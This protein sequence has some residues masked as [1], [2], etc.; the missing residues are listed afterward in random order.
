[1]KLFNI[2]LG[3]TLVFLTV[4]FL[5]CEKVTEVTELVKNTAHLQVTF[6]NDSVPAT[7]VDITDKNEIKK[8]SRFISSET[9]PVRKCKFDGEL[10]FFMEDGIA[11]G[12]GNSVSM[13]FSLQP[14]CAH[15]EYMYA[16]QLETKQLSE[17]GIEFLT[18]MKNK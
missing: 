2:I 16:D 18:E 14:G 3:A 7:H 15:V 6:Y 5:R 8:F 12:G 1:M 13:Q 10:V 11:A 9:I 4:M 17:E